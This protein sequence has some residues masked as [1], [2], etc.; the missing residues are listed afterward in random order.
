MIIKSCYVE[1][2]GTLSKY[3]VEF[4]DGLNSIHKENG[5]GKTT[6][7]VFIKAMLFGIPSGR[8]ADN[9]RK[10]YM[11]WN[12]G[13]FGGNMVF[14]T[15]GK[16][17]RVERTFAKTDK[18]DTFALYDTATNMLC[19]DFGSLLGEEIL[20]VDRESFEKS[21]FI[22]ID[23]YENS[24]LTDVMSAR[25]ADVPYDSTDLD[26]LQEVLLKLDKQASAI[27]AKRGNG[28]LLNQWT[29]K[30]NDD[31]AK[32]REGND[33]R[34]QL[35]E[36]NR[37][38][39]EYEQRL[40]VVSDTAK[41]VGKEI[42]SYSLEHNKKEYERLNSELSDRIAQR[43]N[44]G[45]FFKGNV[46][47]NDDMEC[48]EEH[49]SAYNAH[50]IVA[51][52][53]KLTDEEKKRYEELKAKF[54]SGIPTSEQLD[55]LN[56]DMVR[57]ENA[58]KHSEATIADTDDIIRVERLR[59]RFGKGEVTDTIIDQMIALV[60]KTESLENE[61]NNKKNTY[62]AEKISETAQ[63]QAE[64]DNDNS[65]ARYRKLMRTLLIVSGSVV[66]IG[67]VILIFVSPY[68]GIGMEIGGIIAAVAGF[69]TI[70]PEKKPAMTDTS[71]KTDEKTGVN[72][73][74]DIRA[75]I[76]AD[77]LKYD[78]FIKT[79]GRKEPESDRLKALGDIRS[80][81][82]AYL[83]LDRQI[84]N[85]NEEHTK[86][87][88]EYIEL[89]DR[90]SQVL[91][92]FK[93][94]DSANTPEDILAAIKEAAS[95][96]TEIKK[97][98]DAHN[99]AV[100]EA[101]PHKEAIYEFIKIYFDEVTRPIEQLKQIERRRDEYARLCEEAFNCEQKLKEF[102]LN[103]DTDKLDNVELPK[104][105]L[106]DLNMAQ[107][108][109]S[110]EIADINAAIAKCRQ[111]ADAYGAVADMVSDT[112]DAIAAD[113]EEIDRLNRKLYILNKTKEMLELSGK[114]LSERYMHDLKAAFAKY[115]EI[116]N[117]DSD[118]YH[119]NMKLDVQRDMEGSL[120]D[121]KSF[122]AG[123]KDA[124][125]LCVRLALLDAVYKNGEKP[126]IILDDPF[127]NFDDDR[128]VNAG[129]LVNELSKEY[130]VIYF[131][132]HESRTEKTWQRN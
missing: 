111:Q 34:E 15:A 23:N 131:A 117:T 82:Y 11:P 80:D 4:N 54:G 55:E 10:K 129:K 107:Q 60:Q 124:A 21:V 97:K 121:K 52:K 67:L 57:L 65:D 48:I 98:I 103:N 114:T 77:R 70:K 68:L 90:I 101:V 62:E 120:R 33:A 38:I 83:Q 59:E 31:M 37:Q 94:S 6:L 20:G 87:R 53:N 79:Y 49:I 95:E 75:Q 115:S 85:M 122:S 72:T 2:F 88:A 61:L 64:P 50:A 8:A 91:A 127:V 42:S 14:E 93:T 99:Q 100:K 119:I 47:T 28:G 113:H 89:K 44:A 92:D 123:E 39:A 36:V 96:L 105:S 108:K 46:P 45:A 116:L 35:E 13:V 78:N 12:G 126:V 58:K 32:L 69:F 24:L 112:Q 102:R 9:E 84:S 66:A 41:S 16:T 25:M 56:R 106:N 22:K 30:L 81:R 19:N 5:W 71:V 7:A 104:E 40:R 3:S 109:A 125:E 76:E 110:E 73:A 132:C 74:E 118:S 128:M 130:Q 18:N 51:K 29:D 86:A 1:N 27:K 17:Y 63:V 26:R 43:D